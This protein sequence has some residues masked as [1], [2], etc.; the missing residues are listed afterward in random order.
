MKHRLKIE[1]AA[2]AVVI[3]TLA[4]FMYW[5]FCYLPYGRFNSLLAGDERV[6]VISVTIITRDQKI[7][8]DDPESVRHLTAA[9]RTAKHEGNVP[10]HLGAAYTIDVKMNGVG[11][12]VTTIFVPNDASGWTVTHPGYDSIDP[13]YCWLAFSESTPEPILTAT[14]KLKPR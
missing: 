5:V 6:E 2:T 14:K 13:T 8:I 10:T 1:A 7:V 9:F 4:A 3:F 11:S 12:G